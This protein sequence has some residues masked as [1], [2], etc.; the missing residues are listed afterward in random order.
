MLV[1][2]TNAM[3]RWNE[4]VMPQLG[5]SFVTFDARYVDMGGA[6]SN[7]AIC[8]YIKSRNRHVLPQQVCVP[9]GMR[10]RPIRNVAIQNCLGNSTLVVYK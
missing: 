8:N 10:A 3:N 6:P 1:G 5:S 7:Q 2:R 9:A 4:H